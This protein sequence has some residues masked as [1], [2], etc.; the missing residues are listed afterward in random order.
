MTVFKRILLSLIVVTVLT[1]G[2]FVAA[3]QP[4]P[5]QPPSQQEP[6]QLDEFVPIDQLPQDE[7]IPAAYLL[8]PAYSFVWIAVLIYVVSIA[9]RL[10]T[11]QKEVERLE[12]DLKQGKRT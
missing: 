11:V 8:I 6:K 4:A 2:R 7:Q 10:G 9:K 5:A 1:P 12:A 3:A